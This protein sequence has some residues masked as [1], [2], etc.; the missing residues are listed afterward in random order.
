MK[1]SFTAECESSVSHAQ[2][3]AWRRSKGVGMKGGIGTKR[4]VGKVPKGVFTAAGKHPIGALKEKIPTCEFS[5]V[6]VISLEKAA[7]HAS[8]LSNKIAIFTV[9]F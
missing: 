2:Y 1:V 6:S 5:E 3:E 7:Y 8:H 4:K 9:K